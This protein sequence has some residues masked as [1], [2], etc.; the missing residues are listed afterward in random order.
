LGRKKT[1]KDNETENTEQGVVPLRREKT[2]RKTLNHAWERRTKKEVNFN[3]N[4]AQR[5]KN[6]GIQGLKTLRGRGPKKGEH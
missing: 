2:W 4:N 1:W 6:L 3:I 5:G